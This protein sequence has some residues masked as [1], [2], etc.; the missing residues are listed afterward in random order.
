LIAGPGCEETLHW[1]LRSIQDVVDEIVI[2]DCG[3]SEEAKR[4]ALQY[5]PKLLAASDPRR[6]GFDEA[7]N[8]ALDA[9]TCDW[10]LWIDADEKLVGGNA[11]GKYLRENSYH[12]YTLRQHRFACDV[13]ST[14]DFSARLFR[15]RSRN[16]RTLRFLGAIY[17]Q[18]EFELNDGAGPSVT[19]PD[20]HIAD[21]GNLTEDV[22]QAR[23]ARNWSLL[24]L[25]RQRYPERL[26]Q[27]F[28][29][30]RDN[31]HMVR[32]ALLENGGHVNEPIR[33]ACRQTIELYQRHFLGA[34]TPAT[35][36]ALEYYSQALTVLG[37]GFE[38]VFQVEAG[39]SEAKPNGAQRYR[40][41]SV[42]DFQT[43]LR[44]IASD[45]AAPFDSRWW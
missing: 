38:A 14:T 24:A 29:V 15:R 7:R 32:Y 35:H 19:L 37:E 23:L 28:F 21:V 44:R 8:T 20:V 18:P 17:E 30:M 31:M 42:D 25:D 4:I 45:K 33:D 39:K 5:A 34:R 3:M 6:V 40:F 2:L 41:A 22:R 27:K 11:L 13:G 1:T 12:A 16:G 9:C 43:E 36:D 10:C 26:L